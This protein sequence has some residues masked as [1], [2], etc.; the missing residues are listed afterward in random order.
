[1]TITMTFMSRHPLSTDSS[2]GK[3]QRESLIISGA[4]LGRLLRAATTV[5]TAPTAVKQ[6]HTDAP[7]WYSATGDALTH[8]RNKLLW[9][10][11]GINH[12]RRRLRSGNRSQR[13]RNAMGPWWE[14]RPPPYGIRP[15]S[16]TR[17]RTDSA[18]ATPAARFS[19]P[20]HCRLAERRE[21]TISEKTCATGVG[22]VST[23][24]ICSPPTARSGVSRTGD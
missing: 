4:L 1:M 16:A 9:L 23:L 20:S 24:Y 12:I 6:G 2:W 5:V 10:R 19:S 18:Q 22:Y 7:G 17:I 15:D 3:G 11:W 8:P 21:G 13:G 14:R